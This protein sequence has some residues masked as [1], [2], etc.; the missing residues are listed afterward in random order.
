MTLNEF[1]LAINGASGASEKGIAI[2]E[3]EL[4][5]KLPADYRNFLLKCNGGACGG[6]VIFKRSGPTVHHVFGL[7]AKLSLSWYLKIV[8]KGEGPPVPEDL[9]P[10]MDNPGGYPIC[11]A[12]KGKA[13]GTVYAWTPRA[14]KRLAP[15]FTDFIKG[16]REVP[17]DDDE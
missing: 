3:K 12:W 2:F 13:C 10:I 9:F 7:R 8:R 1:I 14:M 11:M 5:A 6:A 17:E 4:G 15:S 16:L